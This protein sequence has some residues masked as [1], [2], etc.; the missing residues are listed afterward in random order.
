VS[1]SPIAAAADKQQPYLLR[2]F[3]PE[4]AGDEAL[5]QA[6]PLDA[7]RLLPYRSAARAHQVRT[8]IEKTD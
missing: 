1:H 2:L 5:R 7:G 6:E 8:E 3:R 4:T